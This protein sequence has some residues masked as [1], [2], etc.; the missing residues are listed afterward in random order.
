MSQKIHAHSSD[1]HFFGMCDDHFSA[2]LHILSC[3]LSLVFSDMFLI[4][5]NISAQT[6]MGTNAPTCTLTRHCITCIFQTLN[7]L[8]FFISFHILSYVEIHSE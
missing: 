1:M 3:Y 2:S 8:A 5:I 4:C 6:K 7:M